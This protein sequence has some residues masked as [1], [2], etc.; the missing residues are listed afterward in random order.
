MAKVGALIAKYQITNGGPVILVQVENEY[1]GAVAG[2][3]FPNGYYM[4]YIEDQLHNAGIIGTY[5]AEAS[6]SP[7]LE[8][9]VNHSHIVPLISNDASPHGYNAPSTGYPGA[10]DVYGHE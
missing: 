9:G 2:V 5:K 3:D 10:V 7:K 8:S 6:R 4:Q 1:T